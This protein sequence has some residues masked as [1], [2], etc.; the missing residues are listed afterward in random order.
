[1]EKTRKFT[2]GDIDGVIVKPLVKFNDA[3]GWLCELFRQDDI[4]EEFYPVMSY[5]SMTN[6]GVARSPHEHVEQADLFGF[7]GPSM[8]KIYL[9]DNRKHSR[10]FG[11]GMTL[12]AGEDQ[13]KS[14]LIQAGVVHAYKNIGDSMGMVTNYP[15]R[16]FAG[17]GEKEKVYEIR[18]ESDP[19]TL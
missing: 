9:W 17:K 16:L 5:I 15:D 10:T 8:F 2:L 7:L 4:D 19:N 1:M 6:P 13:P 3:R 11:N 12:T 18:H 14:V